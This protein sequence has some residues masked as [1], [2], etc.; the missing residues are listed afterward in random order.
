MLDRQGLL[1]VRGEAT[2]PSPWASVTKLATTL[3]VLVAVEE[4]TVD[5][6]EPAGPPGA[7]VRHLLAHA[8]GLAFDGDAVLAP[9]G[10]RRIYSNTGFDVLG[11]TVAQRTGLPFDRYLS[12][13]VLEP[14]AMTG[15]RLDGSAA[16]G[17]AGTLDD[18]VRLAGEL[19]SPTLV[20]ASTLAIATTVA[21]PGLAGVMPGFGRHDPLDWGLGVE[22]RGAKSPHWTGRTNS[23][24][25]FGHFGRS[26]SFLWVDPRVGLACAV[27]SG[28]DF[29]PW[30]RQEWPAL[31]DS[32]LAELAPPPFG[33]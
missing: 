18:L 3:A 15:A 7:T 27:L 19:L 5:L 16:H 21:F 14:L 10:R 30:C 25:T 22:V 32:V 6:D 13:A 26:G 8:S 11:D 1:A 20:A 31:S 2:A 23:P 28:V 12:E 4:G 24:A 33:E 29:A 17:L 9:P